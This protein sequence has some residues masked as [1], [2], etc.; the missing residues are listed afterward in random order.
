METAKL[1]GDLI[2]ATKYHF[3]TTAVLRLRTLSCSELLR[4]LQRKGG[5]GGRV[6]FLF[7]LWEKGNGSY[8]FTELQDEKV[9]E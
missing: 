3:S 2:T 8:Y 4:Q 9:S 6:H 7:R 5:G 1:T